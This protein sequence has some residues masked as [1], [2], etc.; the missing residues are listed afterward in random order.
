M[1]VGRGGHDGYIGE[2]IE[3]DGQSVAYGCLVVGDDDPNHFV[4]C[5]CGHRGIRARTVQPDSLGPAASVPPWSNKRS[6]MPARP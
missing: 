5:R 1:S 3:H 2:E 6:R 4:R